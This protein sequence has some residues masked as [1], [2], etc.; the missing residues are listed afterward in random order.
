M[1][2]VRTDPGKPGTEQA[3]TWKVVVTGGCLALAVTGCLTYVLHDK[4][5]VARATNAQPSFTQA[6][7]SAGLTPEPPSDITWELMSG[8]TIPV[9][10][11]V[12]P[13]KTDGPVRYGFAHT[14][15]G[16]VLAAANIST[17]YIF[18]PGDGWLQVTQ[19][20]VE[21]SDGR[22][23]FINSRREL[24][25]M[26]PPDGGLGQLAGY[27]LNH[28]TPAKA[29]IQI[30]ETFASGV[31]QTSVLTV[32]WRNGDW[33]LV[34]EPDGGPGPQPTVVNT[35]ASFVPLSSGLFP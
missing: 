33:R 13:T 9:S 34:L 8:V 1:T 35:L 6:K 21:P 23:I 28:Y 2:A 24:T 32:V 10:L 12:G 7:T 29:R 30:A 15:I 26:N 16:A 27:R 20:Q 17:R 14:P 22:D 11:S 31:K 5:S 19:R 4:P 18:A 3:S 25:D